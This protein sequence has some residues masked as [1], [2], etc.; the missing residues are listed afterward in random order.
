[1]QIR[2][3][4]STY[5]SGFHYLFFDASMIEDW[6][7]VFAWQRIGESRRVREVILVRPLCETSIQ[8][9]HN[10]PQLAKVMD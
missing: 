5:F 9:K 4:K 3:A 6:I 10:Y 2:K 1:M 7:N 8:N